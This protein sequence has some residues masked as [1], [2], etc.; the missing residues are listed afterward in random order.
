MLSRRKRIHA[1]YAGL[2]VRGQRRVDFQQV[3][4]RIT[5]MSG[6]YAPFGAILGRR[7]KRYPFCLELRV[8]SIHVLHLENESD[9]VLTVGLRRLVRR[10]DGYCHE[11]A[12]E[13]G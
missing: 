3:A 9:R 6:A 11:V 10:T 13:E 2:L 1:G 12:T 5:K 7:H 4:V 8:D